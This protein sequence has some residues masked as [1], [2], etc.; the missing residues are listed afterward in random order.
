MPNLQALILNSN[1]LTSE[2]LSGLLTST[3]LASVE[4]LSMT[5]NK[6]GKTTI[7]ILPY[8]ERFDEKMN[9]IYMRLKI[10]DLRNNPISSKVHYSLTY[11]LEETIVLIGEFE[12]VSDDLRI[13]DDLKEV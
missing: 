8:S 7:N 12:E 4:L 3:A 2:D 1:R 11:S 10:L 5:S 13:L 9:N 6:I